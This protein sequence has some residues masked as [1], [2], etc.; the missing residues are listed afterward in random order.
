MGT[1]THKIS[2]P[3]LIL[4]WRS[5]GVRASSVALGALALIFF[6]ITTLFFLSHSH[7]SFNGEYF[8]SLPEL[9]GAHP[10]FFLL[11]LLPPLA[12]VISYWGACLWANKTYFIW[13]ED[14]LIIS[15]APLP[16]P[17]SRV[18][19][20]SSE[21]KMLYCEI[22][23]ERYENGAPFK[24]LRLMASFNDRGP[25]VLAH[26]LSVDDEF[27]INCWIQSLPLPSGHGALRPVA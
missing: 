11:L 23:S 10:I 27:K 2:G 22:Y 9:L 4:P 20:H 3:H 5:G 8:S 6:S 26:K 17:N 21:L 7:L 1:P 15:I 19:L 12:L 13:D 16:W 18:V 14:K 25:R 24:E